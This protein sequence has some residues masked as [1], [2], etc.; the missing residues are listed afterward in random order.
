[1][2]RQEFLSQLE[3]LLMDIPAEERQEAIRYYQD[4]FDDAVDIDDDKLIS[5]LGSPE[6]IARQLKVNLYNKA[7]SE[8]GVYTENGYS[9]AFFEESK[10]ELNVIG[11]EEKNYQ[12]T[13][14][15]NGAYQSGA[16]N[17]SYNRPQGRSNNTL[18]III[19]IVTSPIW[20]SLAFGTFF[21]VGGTL[22]GVIV[23]FGAAF[24]GLLVGGV[25][26]VGYGVVQLFFNPLSGVLLI[27]AGF[28]LL[29]IAICFCIL[30]V[31]I[32]SKLIPAIV[33][34]IQY[35][36]NKVFHKEA[37]QYGERN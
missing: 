20:A 29:A 35:V 1:M 15:N 25:T 6:K 3:Q 16:Y 4:Y 30:L 33:R 5:E 36:C 2:S 28:I 18:L 37:R 34:G 13:S 26:C 8:A 9:N 14:Y 22:L 31:L 21:G 17:S 27:G 12:D 7:S 19:L 23:G 10:E 32:V 11:Q 24:L